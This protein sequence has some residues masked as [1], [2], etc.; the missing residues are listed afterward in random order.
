MT[1]KHK[2]MARL[3]KDAYQLVQSFHCTAHRLELSVKD[4]VDTENSVSRFRI[5]VDAIY[6][7]Y[8]QSPRNQREGDR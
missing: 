2:G 6:K 7:G 8:S 3:L 5:L 1:G 4:A